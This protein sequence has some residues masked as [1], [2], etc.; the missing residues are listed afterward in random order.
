[1]LFVNL[2]RVDNPLQIVDAVLRARHQRV[3]QEIVHPINV[4]LRRDELRERGRLKCSFDNA[5]HTLRQF[6]GKGVE[7]TPNLCLVA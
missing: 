6:F 4:Q 5:R 2:K 1:M 3:A 7:H